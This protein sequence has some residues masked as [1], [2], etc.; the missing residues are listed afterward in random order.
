M[1]KNILLGLV[2]LGGI[3]HASHTVCSSP[4]LYYSSIRHDYGVPPPNGT[5]LG[6]LVIVNEG[7][8]LVNETYVQGLGMYGI[9][10]Y[11]VSLV[12]PKKVLYST[13]PAVSKTI[14]YTEVA[15]LRDQKL[16]GNLKE[17]ERTPVVCET[18]QNLVP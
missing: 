5:E 1:K 10:S 14:V 13:G 6:K 17:I 7:K 2:F 18:V 4:S 3:S 12:G 8:V 9:P 15:V 16:P 11:G